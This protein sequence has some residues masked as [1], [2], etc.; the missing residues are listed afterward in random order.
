MALEPTDTISQFFSVF[1]QIIELPQQDVLETDAAAS[2]VE[3]VAA[4]L[5]LG[6]KGIGMGRGDQLLP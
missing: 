2:D 3:V 5:Q 4:V 6:I 1:R